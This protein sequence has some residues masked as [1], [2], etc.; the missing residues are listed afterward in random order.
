M[1]EKKRRWGITKKTLTGIIVFTLLMDLSICISGSI[2]FDKVIQRI[3]NERGYVV[4]NIIIEHIDHDKIAE[5]TKT[6]TAD[7]YYYEMVDYLKYIQ[8]CS[9]AAYIY[10]GVPREDKTIK[11]VYDSGSSI[12][13]EDPIAAPFDELWEAY[14]KGVKPDSYLV[15]HSQYGFLTSSCLPVRDSKGKVVALLFVDTNM[16]I[17]YSTLHT[18]ILN[19]SIISVLLLSLCCVINWHILRKSLIYPLL[20]IKEHLDH[21]A[22]YTSV[23]DNLLEK[24]QTNDELRE[25]AVSVTAMERDIVEYINS[26]QVITSEKEKYSTELNI[27]ARI[28][29]DMLPSLFPAFPERHEFDVFATMT[30]AKEVG[31]DFYDFFL[32]D[33]NH[34]ALVMGDVSGKGVPASLFMVI[35]RTLIKYST[36][37]GGELSPSKILADV[38]NQLCEGNDSDLFVTVWAAIIDLTTGI[39]VA[40]NAGHEHPAIK[41]VNGKYELSIYKH[42]PALAVMEDIKFAEH[43]FKLY[44]GDKLFVY[45]DGVTEATNIFNELYGSD[46]LVEALNK[47]ADA[48]NEVI[49]NRVQ[50]S[51]DA[52]TKGAPQFDDIT[53][54]GFTYYGDNKGEKAK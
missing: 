13:F 23:E 24:V 27:A 16:E 29:S 36:I 19:M 12:G 8:A 28:Q 50:K 25:L 10:I 37:K 53:M 5:Y 44:P 45:T 17:I 18:F 42:S 30:P 54:L 21:F 46:R 14:T 11:Y 26:I 49:L 41:R 43:E 35:S 39:G 47:E 33:N 2:V 3:Y 22:L 38:N 1:G 20:S 52:F 51:I 7:E 48:S 40:A 6:W 31:G 34:I 15:R 32:V 9:D 4:A